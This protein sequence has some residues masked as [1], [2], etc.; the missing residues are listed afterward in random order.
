MPVYPQFNGIRPNVRNVS[1]TNI[2]SVV[3]ASF[4]MFVF[5]IIRSLFAGNSIKGWDNLIYHFKSPFVSQQPLENLRG[6]T[7]FSF[8]MVLI[9]VF[10]MLAI[11]IVSISVKSQK[12]VST[13]KRIKTTKVIC[14]LTVVSFI[15]G[16][17]Y[18]V[19]ELTV[20]VS[21]Y[22]YLV[23]APNAAS[24]YVDLVYVEGVV[25]RALLYAL[26]VMVFSI[27]NMFN[28]NAFL[29]ELERLP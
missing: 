23:E 12:N 17:I 27:A 21:F 18:L 14:G 10:L 9:M 29:K 24:L 11:F 19:A 20:V 6:A 2:L 16:A 15:C 22:N 13:N 4:A 26:V 8:A 1:E 5:F 28:A 3:V 25:S 7:A